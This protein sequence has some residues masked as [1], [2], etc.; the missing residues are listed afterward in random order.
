[1][2]SYGKAL[3]GFLRARPAQII[4]AALVAWLLLFFVLTVRLDWLREHGHRCAPVVVGTV[5]FI[6]CAPDWESYRPLGAQR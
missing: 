1:V 2:K 6:R 3:L 4:A 5:A